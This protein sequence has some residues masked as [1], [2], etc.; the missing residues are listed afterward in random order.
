MT[1]E[2]WLASIAGD[3]VIIRLVIIA[4]LVDSLVI[5]RMIGHAIGERLFGAP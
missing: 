2:L 4:A 3:P 5:G 1:L